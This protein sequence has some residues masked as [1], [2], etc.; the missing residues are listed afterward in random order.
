MSLQ[1][2]AAVVTGA[3]SG[4]GQAIA[5]ALARRG[6]DIFI[7]AHRNRAGCDNTAEAVRAAGRDCDVWLCDLGEAS[8]AELLVERAW[9]WR[10][11]DIWVNNAG[12]DVLT[13]AMAERS[14]D[15][16]LEALWRVDV[17]ATARL[18]RAAC[19]RMKQRGSGV[20]LNMGWD[21]AETGMAGESG[22]MFAMTKGAVMALTASLAKSFA[23]EVRVNCLAPGWIKTAWAGDASDYWQ[24]R[25][26][27]E[28][29]R[30]RWGTPED[31]ARVAAF[32]ASADADFINGQIVPING[33]FNSTAE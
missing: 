26:K 18:S 13:G 14:F 19:Q 9:Q 29:L 1:G 3:S 33:G 17:A 2:Q 30:N 10:P 25:A 15:D 27:Q 21:Q 8:N 24:Q 31:V 7:H 32:L 12:V 22:Q 4:I 16:K 28:S 5:I 6:A 11:I 20:I 23:P